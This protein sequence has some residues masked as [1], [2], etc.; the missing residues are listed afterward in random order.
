MVGEFGCGEPPLLLLP[1]PLFIV[2]VGLLV[3]TLRLNF[4]LTS[5]LRYA[6]CGADV[7]GAVVL[8]ADVVVAVAVAFVVVCGRWRE[9]VIAVDVVATIAVAVVVDDDDDDAG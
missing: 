2:V 8:V 3:A 7:I 4:L 9:C 5:F 6:K 1:L